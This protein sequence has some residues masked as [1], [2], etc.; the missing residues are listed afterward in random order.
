ME[1]SESD[2]LHYRLISVN[3]SVDVLA[4]GFGNTETYMIRRQELCK[5]SVFRSLNVSFVLDE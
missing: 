2:H 1:G 5:I 3:C 4:L